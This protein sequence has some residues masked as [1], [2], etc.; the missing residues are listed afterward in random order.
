MILNILEEATSGITKKATENSLIK[1]RKKKKKI[2][3]AKN[4]FYVTVHNVNIDIKKYI[5]YL[6]QPQ[7]LLNPPYLHLYVT[8]F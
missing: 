5:E 1:H 2:D 4:H 6:H 3:Y 7:S 8:S